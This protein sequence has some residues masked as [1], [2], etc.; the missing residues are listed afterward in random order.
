M[1]NSLHCFKN[2]LFL[3]GLFLV[4]TACGPSKNETSFKKMDWLLGTWQTTII[5]KTTEKWKAID[6]T[7]YQA[8]SFMLE[9]KDTIFSEEMELKVIDK[10]IYYIPSFEGQSGEM[11]A[12]FKLVKQLENQVTF[13]NKKHDYPQRIIYKLVSPDTLLARLEGKQGGQK[14]EYNFYFSRKN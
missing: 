2:C 5:P 11:A 1:K 7:H 8:Q 12:K 13:E 10:D 4:L 6:N 9:N 3:A 14:K